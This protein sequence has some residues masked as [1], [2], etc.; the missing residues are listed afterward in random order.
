MPEGDTLHRTATVLRATLLGEVVVAA[1]ARP[2][3]ARLD[4]VVGSRIDRVDA[5]GKHLLI[6]FDVGSTLHTH[7]RMEGSWH[8]YRP[9]E[10]WRYLQSRAVAV[11]ETPT[12]VAV[13]FDAPTVELIETRALSLHPALA[14]LGPDLLASEPDIPSAVA[15]LLEPSR[16]SM[17]I[18]EAL[19]DQTAV[20][21]IGNVY[22]SEVLWTASV[23]PFASPSQVG[24]ATLQGIIRSAAAMLRANLDG[25]PRR[26]RERGPRL[27][28]YERTGRPCLRCGT[29]IRSTMLGELPRRLYW[30]PRCQ[31]SGRPITSG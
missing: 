2:G 31:P 27:A 13:C 26:T 23:D 29:A 30:C 6:G 11:I 14:T 17:T 22:R 3:G 24:E 28:V 25:R 15:R 8:R 9:R 21:G 4:R 12:A 10:P 18:A 5:V 19:L 20:A 7:L 16:S 1:R